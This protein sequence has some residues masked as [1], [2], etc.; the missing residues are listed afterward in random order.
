MTYI[1]DL[2]VMANIVQKTF[3]DDGNFLEV[4]SKAF[5]EQFKLTSL[6]QVIAWHSIS[7]KQ[8]PEPMMTQVTDEYMPN[9]ASM[10]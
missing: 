4:Y 3:S 6:V 1:R 9:Q 7:V 8:L 2:T 10:S 5:Y